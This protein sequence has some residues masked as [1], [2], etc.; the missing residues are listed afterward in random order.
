MTGKGLR[1][2]WASN[3]VEFLGLWSL[4]ENSSIYI[5]SCMFYFNKNF[6]CIF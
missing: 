1:G 6:T 5:L 4:R 3:R 2:V